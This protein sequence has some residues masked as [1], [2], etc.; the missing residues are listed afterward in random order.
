MMQMQFKHIYEPRH[1]IKNLM[2][3][4]KHS[5]IP[6]C[7]NIKNQCHRYFISTGPSNDIPGNVE[8]LIFNK[9]L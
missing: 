2:L 6:Q 3:M 8:Q 5:P 4:N 1:N 7:I 9:T